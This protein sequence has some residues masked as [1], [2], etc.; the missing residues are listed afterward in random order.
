M[1]CTWTV[2]LTDTPQKY[3]RLQAKV[4]RFFSEKCC[5]K[6]TI[7]TDRVYAGTYGHDDSFDMNWSNQQSSKYI[8]RYYYASGSSL[9]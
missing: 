1:D 2:T 6:L 8:S 4:E 7:G 9:T 5:D 3:Y